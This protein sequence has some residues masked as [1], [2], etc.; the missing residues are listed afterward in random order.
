[1][2]H[3]KELDTGGVRQFVLEHYARLARWEAITGMPHRGT[4]ALTKQE[5]R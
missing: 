5:E 2:H 1:M 3:R 4:A